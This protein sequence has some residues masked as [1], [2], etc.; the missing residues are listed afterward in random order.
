MPSVHEAAPVAVAT[1]SPFDARQ[2]HR[3]QAG[4][5]PLVP[6]ELLSVPPNV[7]PPPEQRAPAASAPTPAVAAPESAPMEAKLP[8]AKPFSPVQEGQRTLA[9][10]PDAR[11]AAAAASQAQSTG[12]LESRVASTARETPQARAHEGKVIPFPARRE[13]ELAASEGAA[14]AAVPAVAEDEPPGSVAPNTPRMPHVLA[15]QQAVALERQKNEAQRSVAPAEPT[16]REPA[17]ERRRER[18]E[19]VGNQT[20][21]LG[22]GLPGLGAESERGPVPVKPA[23]ALLSSQQPLGATQRFGSGGGTQPLDLRASSPGLDAPPVSSSALRQ[24]RDADKPSS[25]RSHADTPH[26]ALHDEFFDAGEQGIYAGGHGAESRHQV[27]DDE[28]EHDLPRIVVRTPE[29]ERRRNKMMQVVGVVV[30]V[31]LGVFVFAILRG[32]ASSGEEAKN[33]EQQ[34]SEHAAP[35]PAPVQPP[36]PPAAVTLPPPPP[37]PEVVT[38]PPP[39]PPPEPAPVEPK[40]VEKPHV[41][42]PPAAAA[43]PAEPTPRARPEPAPPR[44][45]GPAG[46]QPR[47]SGPLLPPIPTGKPPTVSFPD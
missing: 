35:P 33:P 16:V 40:A 28:L 25:S 38:P 20:L 34:P 32:R 44:T 42:A 7:A 14:A 1:P 6:A 45:P 11:A 46:V 12:P 23:A 27:L 10:S 47:P 41:V 4:L 18:E 22:S 17:L 3:T 9:D 8:E 19:H 43:H 29:Q 30:G 15:A 37:E 31:V 39:P 26:E 21:N 2:A 5:G 24:Q 36:A 13:D